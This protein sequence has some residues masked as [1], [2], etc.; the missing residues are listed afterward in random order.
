MRGGYE[1]RLVLA[2]GGV[3]E[4]R[5]DVRLVQLGEVRDN[6][7]VRHA[8]RQP[9]QHIRHRDAHPAHARFATPLARLKSDY[10]LVVHD[11]KLAFRRRLAKPLLLGRAIR[12][13]FVS[14]KLAGMV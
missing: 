6:L 11:G 8:A 10:A 4:A 13:P 14:R 9:A 7:R 1:V 5:A 3:G 2:V 12:R